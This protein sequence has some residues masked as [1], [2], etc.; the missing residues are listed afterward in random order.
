MGNTRPGN[1]KTHASTSRL[2]GNRTPYDYYWANAGSND[3]AFPLFGP[4]DPAHHSHLDAIIE[5]LTDLEKLLQHAGV[6]GGIAYWLA[7]AHTQELW[8]VPMN[9]NGGFYGGYGY[10]P[11]NPMAGMANEIISTSGA[12]PG[13]GSWWEVL[14]PNVLNTLLPRIPLPGGGGPAAQIPGTVLRST[15]RGLGSMA[16]IIGVLTAAGVST[17]VIMSLIASGAIK[18]T[19]RKRGISAAELRGFNKISA[20]LCRVGMVPARTR[21]GCSRKRCK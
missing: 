20:L 7:G 10:D 4:V 13:A 2:R 11:Y 15:G 17:E 6:P 18:P 5:A 14:I 1:G 3:D 9:G 19:R 16:K 12:P 21:R 8:G